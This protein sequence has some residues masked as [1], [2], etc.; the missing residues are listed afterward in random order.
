MSISSLPWPDEQIEALAAAYPTPFY[1]YD[2]RGIR[3][4]ARALIDAFAWAPRFQEFFAVKA[5][6][7]P[8]IMSILASEGCGMDCSS[9][10]ELLLAERAGVTGEQIMFSSNNT[11]AEEYQAAMRAGALLNLDDVSHLDYLE[12]CA[13]LPATLSFRYNPGPQRQGNAIIGKPEEA[14]FGAT[15]EQ[16]LEGYA[17]ARARGV[18]HFGLH[19][20]VASNELD[21]AYF[22]ETAR[23][24][25]QLAADIAGEVGIRMQFVNL[26]GGIGIPYR[27][28]Q[29][30]VDLAAVSAG[31]RAAYQAIVVPAG[32]HPLAIFMECGRVITGPHGY[33]VTRVRHIKHTYRQ[34]AGVDASMADLMRPGMYGAYHHITALGRG[35]SAPR[36]RYDV[37]G[38]LCENNDKFAIER[39]LPELAPGDLLVIHDSGAHGRSMGFNY[40]GKLRAAE[41]LMR[42]D[43]TPRLIRRAETLEDYFATLQIAD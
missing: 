9:L 37:T 21:P 31:I 33:L 34:F 20:M 24:L 42:P 35:A 12:A 11:P 28:E 16:L 22:V 1:L 26:G 38:S 4:A 14:K 43:G 7:N 27:P 5:T 3:A 13:G 32:L 10:A 40:N 36:Q 17:A 6:P 25:F 39:E 29:R 19:T 15:R 23:M 41:L 18:R 2:E 8:S 30:P